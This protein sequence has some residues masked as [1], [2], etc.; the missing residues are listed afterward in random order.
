M[1]TRTS[2]KGE[3]EKEWQRNRVERIGKKRKQKRERVKKRNSKISYSF[4]I[5]NKMIAQR[6]TLN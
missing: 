3:K 2:R 5:E 4:R 1:K 6:N